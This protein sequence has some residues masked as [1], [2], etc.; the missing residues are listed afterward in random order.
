M[1]FHLAAES[2]PMRWARC[3]M[4][5]HWLHLSIV[6]SIN[7][8]MPLSQTQYSQL[9][10]NTR[11]W[12]TTLYLYNTL[13]TFHKACNGWNNPKD[14]RNLTT[15]VTF[16]KALSCWKF[17]FQNAILKCKSCDCPC[18]RFHVQVYVIY[19]LILWFNFFTHCVVGLLSLCKHV[20]WSCVFIINLFT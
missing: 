9:S 14:C 3:R 18:P 13:F 7:A 12:S 20:L 1:S 10:I 16:H 6:S 11:R 17:L 2:S 19:H 15:T 4:L 5:F 8:I